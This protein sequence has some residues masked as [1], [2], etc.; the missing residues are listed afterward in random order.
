MN[1]F[2]SAA[3][4]SHENN[5]DI[6]PRVSDVFK[7]K[8]DELVPVFSD[9]EIIKSEKITNTYNPKNTLYQLSFLVATQQSSP[10]SQL[11]CCICG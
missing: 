10:C 3:P 8:S 1:L 6:H 11:E 7:I 9:S 2:D 5:F 4:K